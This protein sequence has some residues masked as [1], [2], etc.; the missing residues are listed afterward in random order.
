[1]KKNFLSFILF[2]LFYLLLTTLFANDFTVDKIN[3]FAFAQHFNRDDAL[4]VEYPYLF[5]LTSH[6]LEIYEIQDDLQLQQLSV[7]TITSPYR[8]VI[9][10]N[11]IYISNDTPFDYD[12]YSLCLYQVDITDKE[13]P[14]I[15]N[16]IE[17]DNSFQYFD[18]IIFDDYLYLRNFGIA[19]TIYSLPDLEFFAT[20][21][22]IIDI[23]KITETIGIDIT[24][25]NGIDIYDLSNFTNIQLIGNIDMS[26]IE[27][28]YSPF[29]YQT[30]NDTILIASS[31]SVVSFWNI[32][33]IANWEYISHYES[34]DYMI[35]GANFS[36]IG[37]YLILTQFVGFELIDISDIENPYHVDFIACYHPYTKARYNEN[38]YV[39]TRGDGI[40]RYDVMD[41]EISY[42]E[43]YFN[44]SGFY[45]GY[46]YSH[47]LFVQTYLYGI[48]LFDIEDPNN[49]VEIVT[50]L[51]NPDFKVLQ[52]YENLL[53]VKDWYD[54]SYKIFDISDPLNPILTNTILI[55]DWLQISW[56]YL[57]FDDAEP[58]TV[59]FFTIY[60]NTIIR[61]YDISEPGIPVLLFEYTDLDGRSFFVRDGYGYLLDDVYNYQNLYIIDGLYEN[62]PFLANTIEHFSNYQYYP[63]IDLYNNYLCLRYSSEYDETKF[64][65]LNDPLF[66]EF[67]FELDV[68]SNS[69]PV[70]NFNNFIFTKNSVSSYIY[71]ISGTP[72]GILEPID[73][74]YGLTYIRTIDFYESDENNYLFT[75]EES[76]IGVFEFSYTHSVDDEI[77]NQGKITLNNYPNPFSTST[78][79]SFSATGPCYAT[80]RQAKSHEMARIKI[81]NIKG[82][83]IKQLSIIN[84]SRYISGSIE[85]YGKDENGKQVPSGIYLCKLTVGKETIV[86]KVV[87]LR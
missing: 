67:A 28:N 48:H 72:S 11:F 54:Y 83:L 49:P 21:P 29:F 10:D 74:I 66:P 71:D 46:I 22:D 30:I 38:L 43:N 6:G 44:Y 60:P 16:Q 62:V 25:Y 51:S 84:S 41:D 76:D 1:M 70:S 18:L 42:I 53:A 75:I 27:P 19:D 50:I 33:D 73:S 14:Y 58:N 52:G 77:L 8:Y 15:Y 47:Y 80:P 45:N 5:A 87:L 12:L 63:Y 81:Y 56:S 57:R 36:I 35:Y 34:Q 20:I 78:T 82:E 23:Y 2:P 3:E 9:N 68:P 17:F 59:Y 65:N 24:Y 40:H 61:K 7:L 55:G 26:F 4:K 64:F 13:N 37:N 69:G 85:W 86:R 31:Q 39:G 32:S 79:I